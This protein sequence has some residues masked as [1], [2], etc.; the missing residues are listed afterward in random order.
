MSV[1]RLS[2]CANPD[3]SNQFKRLGSGKIYTLP[4]DD[5]KAWGLAP[6][7]RQKVVWLCGKC[8]ATREVAFDLVRHE[9]QVVGKRAWGRQSA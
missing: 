6:Q 8:A 5:P 9:V 4:V 7:V 2:K 1:P 3:C